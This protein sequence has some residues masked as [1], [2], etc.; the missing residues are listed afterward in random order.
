[1]VTGTAAPREGAA[2]FWAVSAWVA[3]SAPCHR[4]Q[5]KYP[6]AATAAIGK[7]QRMARDLVMCARRFKN[8]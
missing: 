3:G 6:A 7:I 8:K 4:C 5:P 2:D 1:M